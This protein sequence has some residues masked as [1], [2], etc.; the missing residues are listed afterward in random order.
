MATTRHRLGGHQTVIRGGQCVR[1]DQ[2]G[3]G[4]D[5]N[6]RRYLKQDGCSGHVFLRVCGAAALVHVVI[7][8][9][10]LTPAHKCHRE[11]SEHL[12]KPP[13]PPERHQINPGVNGHLS[14]RRAT[15][16]K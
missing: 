11:T 10:S 5:Q 7:P 3:G 9:L 16:Y 4:S 13:E 14:H 6:Q 1:E 8:S 15:L 12:L 2:S